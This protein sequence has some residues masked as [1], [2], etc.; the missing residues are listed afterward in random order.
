ME[1]LK[2]LHRPARC[3]HLIGQSIGSACCC[4]SYRNQIDCRPCTTSVLLGKEKDNWTCDVADPKDL[5]QGPHIKT[6]KV[7]SSVCVHTNGKIPFTSKHQQ[8]IQEFNSKWSTENYFICP[9]FNISMNIP[10][11][12]VSSCR[13]YRGRE[14]L[15]AVMVKTT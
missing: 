9:I 1:K 7:S 3:S 10:Q 4:Q 12:G 13:E 11:S 5:L 14:T 8:S 6:N 15:M 2:S